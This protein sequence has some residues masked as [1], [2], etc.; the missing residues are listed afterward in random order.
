MIEKKMKTYLDKLPRQYKVKV[1]YKEFLTTIHIA[2]ISFIYNPSTK[3]I[4]LSGQTN[5]YSDCITFITKNLGQ[6][7]TSDYIF[8]PFILKT[9]K[10]KGLTLFQ[11]SQIP[12]YTGNDE[13]R[14]D[15]IDYIYWLKTREITGECKLSVDQFVLNHKNLNNLTLLEK[16]YKIK[17]I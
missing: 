16:K 1:I 11:V 6:Y 12:S 17:T 7:I 9:G 8:N 13:N 15:G 2:G 10:Y 4:K 5:W 3:K 14:Y